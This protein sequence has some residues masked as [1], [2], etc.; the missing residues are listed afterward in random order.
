MDPRKRLERLYGRQ[1]LVD[2]IP[3]ELPVDSRDTPALMAAFPVS[4]ARAAELLPGEE[5]HPLR[6]PGDRGVLVVGVTDSGT[7]DS[8]SYVGFSSATPGAGGR[9][10]P[11]PVLPAALQG[12]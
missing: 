5:V 4:A 6:L 3:F 11:P 1:A 10:P 8:G 12:R 7:T 9:E 2:G